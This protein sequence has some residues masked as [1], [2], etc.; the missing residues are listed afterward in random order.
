MT[1]KNEKYLADSKIIRN[2]A[3]FSGMRGSTKPLILC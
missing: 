2:F 3:A 1:R